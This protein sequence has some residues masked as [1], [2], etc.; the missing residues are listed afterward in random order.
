[1]KSIYLGESFINKYDIIFSYLYF[2]QYK[3][4]LLNDIPKTSDKSKFIGLPLLSNSS[5]YHKINLKVTNRLLR[6]VLK[7]PLF[8]ISCCGIY[9]FWNAIV[10]IQFINKIKPEIIHINNGGFPAS[11]VCNQFAFVLKLFYPE[12]KIVYQVNSSPSSNSVILVKIINWAAN[13]FITHSNSN[14]LKLLKIGMSDDKVKSFPS[15]FEDEFSENLKLLDSSLFN[16][17][18][19]GFLEKRKGHIYLIQAISLIKDLNLDL[20]NKIHLHII[21]SGE[22][23]EYLFHYI[24][25]NKLQSKVTLWGNRVDY[26]YFIKFCDVFALPSIYDEDLPL[27]LL[28]AMKY[29]KRIIST[30]LAGIGEILSNGFDALLVDIDLSDISYNLGSSI[31]DVFSNKAL[32]DNLSNNIKNT[33]ES[34]FSESVYFKN[35]DLLYT[36]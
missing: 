15:F 8:F 28:S 9:F 13:F 24:H 16:I 1:M 10:I 22:E 5:F 21:G 17:V 23:Y 18:T 14:R 26:L 29:N 2:E 33:Y 3:K 19:V 32:R 30:K 25:E 27:V 12:V 7:F 4:A 6:R 20:Y 36:K 35:L 31:V 34:R 11:E